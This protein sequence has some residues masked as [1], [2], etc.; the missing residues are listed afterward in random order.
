MYRRRRGLTQEELADR[1]G[2]NVR[3]IGKIEANKI[4]VPRPATMGRLA[5]AFEL[6]GD[7]R[8]RFGDAASESSEAPPPTGAVPSRES[9]DTPAR[10]AQLPANVAGFVGRSEQLDQ[11]MSLL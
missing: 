5:D 2:I 6:T 9:P 7:E 8:E 3:T 11:L 1:L 10:P 4:A